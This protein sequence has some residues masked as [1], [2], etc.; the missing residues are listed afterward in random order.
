MSIKPVAKKAKQEG[1]S[2][3]LA[4]LA[5]TFNAFIPFARRY[6]LAQQVNTMKKKITST[7]MRGISRIDQPAKRTHGFFVRLTRRGKTY[8]AFFTD[9]RYGGK[10]RALAAAQKHYRKLL[11]KFGPPL[12]K[13]RR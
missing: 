5:Y 7:R 13:R 12:R 4:S 6:T 11:A 2:I 10:K 9:Q 1:F 8:S 3:L